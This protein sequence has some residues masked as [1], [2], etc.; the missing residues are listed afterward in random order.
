MVYDKQYCGQWNI[1]YTAFLNPINQ[2]MKIGGGF[3][4]L[5]ETM[6][7]RIKN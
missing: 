4:R 3:H 6:I 1:L 2:N 5:L 7:E